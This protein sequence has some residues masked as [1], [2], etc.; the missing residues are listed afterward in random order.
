MDGGIGSLFGMNVHFKIYH[1]CDRGILPC[2][3][4]VNLGIPSSYVLRSSTV[5]KYFNAGVL[6]ME[7]VFPDEETSC[8][9]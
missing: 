3:R 1:N 6:N 4:K 7:F 5:T 8:L 2:K 9:N